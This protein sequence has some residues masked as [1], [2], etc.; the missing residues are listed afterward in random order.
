M[1]WGRNLPATASRRRHWQMFCGSG[2]SVSEVR[3]ALIG[4]SVASFTVALWAQCAWN[5]K[6][7]R[8][9]LIRLHG[10]KAPDGLSALPSWRAV[11]ALRVSGRS[12]LTRSR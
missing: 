4:C 8:M 6:D 1:Q 10:T 7:K 2:E 3:E 5:S 12:C 9:S 11:L